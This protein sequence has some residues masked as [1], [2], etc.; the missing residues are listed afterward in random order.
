MS[1]SDL[2]IT[3]DDCQ[4]I[5]RAAAA[6]RAANVALHRAC[7]QKLTAWW[8]LR[9][10]GRQGARWRRSCRLARPALTDEKVARGRQNLPGQPAGAGGS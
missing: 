1:G 4:I 8:Q 7:S 2:V 6:A 3:D 10:R 5:G 9:G